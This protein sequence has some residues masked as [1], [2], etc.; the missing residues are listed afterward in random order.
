MIRVYESQTATPI[1]AATVSVVGAHGEIASTGTTDSNGIAVIQVPPA[2]SCPCPFIVVRAKAFSM[3]ALS[4]D[5][6]KAEYYIELARLAA[7]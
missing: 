4:F 2:S 6:R 1:A 7:L 3:G 5:D